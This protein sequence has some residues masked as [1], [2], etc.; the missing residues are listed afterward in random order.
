MRKTL[1]PA[2][3]PLALLSIVALASPVMASPPP[4]SRIDVF[5]ARPAP[6]PDV[7]R[8]TVQALDQAE[9]LARAH[10]RDLGHPWVDPSTGSVVIA[11]VTPAGAH[12]AAQ[13]RNKLAAGASVIRKSVRESVASLEKI[14]DEAIRPSIV[15]DAAAI[16][17]TRVDAETNR[18][19][20]TATRTTPAMLRGLSERYGDRAIAVEVSPRFNAEK[21]SRWDEGPDNW[22]GGGATQVHRNEGQTRCTTGIPVWME[23][24]KSGMLTAGHCSPTGGYYFSGNDN[25]YM[26]WVGSGDRENYNKGTGSVRLPGQSAYHGDLAL[27]EIPY[28]T[29]G[30]YLFRGSA[31]GGYTAIISQIWPWASAAAGAAAAG[32]ICTGGSTTGENCGWIA[33]RAGVNVKYSDGDVVRN[34][35]EQVKD[36]KC[37]DGGDSGGPVYWLKSDGTV[38]VRGIISGGSNLGGYGGCRLYFTEVWD[39]V[40]AWDDKIFPRVLPS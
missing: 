39:A 28:G 19:V 30:Y 14:K 36:G 5:S 8:P 29:S 38:G 31:S 10:P 33:S 4:P 26:G 18:V 37:I 16:R 35:T 13:R 22:G 3:G 40:A 6:S 20:I 23:G 34:M 21:A 1:L 2:V 15:P 25:N 9:K 17:A 24:D 11:T 27:I 7:P 12:L 32:D